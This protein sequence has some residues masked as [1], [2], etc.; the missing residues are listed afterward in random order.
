M[1]AP[2]TLILLRHG[3][4]VLNAQDRFT[5]LLNPSLS[6]IGEDEAARAGALLTSASFS[7]DTLYTSTLTRTRDT[8]RIVLKVLDAPDVPVRAAW[9]LNERS[10]G[11]LTGRARSE[12][13]SELG[14]EV[15]RFWRRS[16]YGAP[17]PMSRTALGA[18]RRS[19]AFA[20]L[21][22]EAL[23]PTESLCGVVKRVRIFWHQHLRPRIL[24]G[25]NVLVIGHGNSLRALC[26]VLDRLSHAEVEELN[27]PTGHPLQY[28]FDPGLV[29]LV[30]GGEYLNPLAARTAAAL[31]A[32]AGGT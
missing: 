18:I 3:Q 11:S 21:P 4:S 7:P 2:G 23:L 1:P 15:F 25:E 31:V 27:I 10:Y 32:A 19:R 26:L 22:P 8:A 17:P 29:P 24:A 9:E 14:P 30:R 28:R 5:G 16:Y 20:G 12:M 13:L 6:S